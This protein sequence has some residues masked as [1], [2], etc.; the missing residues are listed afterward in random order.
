MLPAWDRVDWVHISG[1]GEVHLEGSVPF[2]RG[3]CWEPRGPAPHC[4]HPSLPWTLSF[5]V[6]WA[7][8]AA[9][10]S[11]ACAP[12]KTE[13]STP[14]QGHLVL[15]EASCWLKWALTMLKTQPSDVKQ[16][17]GW[18][19]IASYMTGLAFGEWAGRQ[20]LH[21]S[22]NLAEFLNHVK[23]SFVCGTGKIW[24]GTFTLDKFKLTPNQT[25]NQIQWS[26]KQSLC[27]SF[28][29]LST[30]MNT[31]E[32]TKTKVIHGWLVSKETKGRK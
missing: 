25:A 21:L 1:S 30:N 27:R 18:R 3:G 5:W 31:N 8:G 28:L 10:A 4:C 13:T 11:P 2:C 32:S 15:A 29:L 17:N 20:L 24:Q 7:G 23:I 16:T 12:L 14:L 22:S 6:S 9:A 26:S 19:E